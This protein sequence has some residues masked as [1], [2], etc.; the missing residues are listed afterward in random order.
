MKLN[1]ENLKQVNDNLNKDI[2]ELIGDLI[3][4]RDSNSD[5]F[6]KLTNFEYHT[7][8]ISIRYG[9]IIQELKQGG[10]DE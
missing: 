7:A 3:K 8:R 9:L 1:Y 6:L 10:Y 2:D 4:I 5:L